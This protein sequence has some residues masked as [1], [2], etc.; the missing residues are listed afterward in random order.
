MVLLIAGPPEM[1]ITGEQSSRACARGYRNEQWTA[2]SRHGRRSVFGP[3]FDRLRRPSQVV[4]QVTD[5]MN[6]RRSVPAA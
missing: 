1:G 2:S 4:E 5:L 3:G 6:R